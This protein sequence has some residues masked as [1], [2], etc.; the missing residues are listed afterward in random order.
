M[1]RK[2][3]RGYVRRILAFESGPGWAGVYFTV[4]ALAG[5]K[6]GNALFP[7]RARARLFY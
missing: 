5:R 6:P 4:L 7:V 2:A 1:E 3:S